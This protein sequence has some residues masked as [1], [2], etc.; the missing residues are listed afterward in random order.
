M[1]TIW[2]VGLLVLLAGGTGWCASIA[3]VK[4][5]G[6]WMQ[7]TVEGI[8]TYLEPLECYVESADRSG[9]I[10]VRGSTEGIS[11][12]DSVLAGGTFAVVDGEPAVTAASITKQGIPSVIRPFG[13]SNAS[14]GGASKWSP[15]SVTDFRGGAWIPARG[16][17]N[18]GLL[19]TTWGTVRAIYYSP[20]S[21]ARWLYIDD[22]S[23]VVSDSGDSGVLV[24]TDAEVNRGDFVRLTGVSSTEPAMDGP[25]RLIRVVRTRSAHDVRVEKAQELPD[26]SALQFSDEFDEP[27]VDPRWSLWSHWPQDAVSLKIM[28]GWLTLVLESVSY[29]DQ[30]GSSVGVSQYGGGDWD[31]E[32][33]TRMVQPDGP[34]RFTWRFSVSAGSSAIAAELRGSYQNPITIVLGGRTVGVLEGDICYFRLRKRGTTLWSSA[35]LDGVTYTAEEQAACPGINPG[36]GM[37]ATVLSI[38]GHYQRLYAQIDYFRITPVGGGGL[39]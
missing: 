21:G 13:M 33:R 3:E 1:R 8:V 15:V 26:R 38:S 20:V 25:P 17:N 29:Q 39:Q 7:V 24:Y 22:G 18:T 27:E 5:A 12:G 37:G 31:L 36:V 23:G 10:W 11:V 16:A 28:P 9:G 14:L 2:F 32:V 6:N 19:V 34:L 30:V 35:S 4:S